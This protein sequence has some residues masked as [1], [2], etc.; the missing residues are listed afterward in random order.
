MPTDT[1][2]LLRDAGGARPTSDVDALIERL[3]S[4]TDKWYCRDAAA[5]LVQLRDENAE[6]RDG[7]YGVNKLAQRVAS[8]EIRAELAEAELD[9]QN[10]ALA[11]C[12]ALLKQECDD[13]VPLR[14][15]VA[16]FEASGGVAAHTEVFEQM[17]RAE[18]AKAE[19]AQ[20]RDNGTRL[21][22]AADSWKDEAQR[23]QRLVAELERERN[24]LAK[25]AEQSGTMLQWILSNAE[26]RLGVNS[27]GK[28]NY[29]VVP[30]EVIDAA[31]KKP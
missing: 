11:Q 21:L 6:Y 3:N 14:E 5:A 24:A 29:Y 22:E 15:R 26:Y 17:H 10:R 23:N 27:L 16:W 28:P 7:E 12:R 19:V 9:T 8:A 25:D 18:R 1:D 20:L 30:A 13:V 4:N 2:G 31:R